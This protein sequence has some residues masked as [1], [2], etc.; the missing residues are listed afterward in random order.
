VILS[1]CA[2]TDRPGGGGGGA[3][4]EGRATPSG[5]RA[6]RRQEDED[7]PLGAAAPV[8]LNAATRI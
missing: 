7:A 2:N 3:E 1:A 4:S 6:S 8:R 5:M